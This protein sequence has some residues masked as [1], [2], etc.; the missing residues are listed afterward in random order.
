[1]NYLDTLS[2]LAELQQALLVESI[3]QAESHFT[4]VES[5]LVDDCCFGRLAK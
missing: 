3:R 5:T 2:T 4:V 1:V